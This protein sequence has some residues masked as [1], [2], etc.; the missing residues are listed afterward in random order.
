[1]KIPVERTI[2]KI[3]TNL[4]RLLGFAIASIR[5]DARTCIER[6]RRVSAKGPLNQYAALKSSD[7]T[8]DRLVFAEK[9]FSIRHPWHLSVRVDRAYDNGSELV[10]LKLKTRMTQRI[11]LTDII[12]LSSQ[13]VA[14]HYSTRRDVSRHAYVLLV[15]P[16]LR[17]QTLHRVALI[18][19]RTIMD[20]A[21][22]REK[23]LAGLAEPA[24]PRGTP[25]CK[26]CEYRVECDRRQENQIGRASCRERV[27]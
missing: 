22:R 14:V 2:A 6:L 10:L 1:M 27:L 5:A 3:A 15:Q 7:L 8:E 24:R 19:E 25:L 20:L 9:E 26:R 17:K 13:R 11:Y 23:L 18:P 16:L 21:H 12:E 4:V